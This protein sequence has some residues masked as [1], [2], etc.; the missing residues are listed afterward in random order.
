[1][2]GYREASK[3]C[4]RP[5]NRHTPH[6]ATAQLAHVSGRFQVVKRAMLHPMCNQVP[7][8]LANT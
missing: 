6:L 4:V 5:Q 3:G 1:M 8:H 2:G 7:L